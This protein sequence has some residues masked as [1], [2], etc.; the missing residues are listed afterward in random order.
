MF[1]M[2]SY[3]CYD[4]VEGKVACKGKILI[5]N[6]AAESYHPNVFGVALTLAILSGALENGNVPIGASLRMLQI[7][8]KESRGLLIVRNSQPLHLKS[9]NPHIV[10]LGTQKQDKASSPFKSLSLRS[11]VFRFPKY[12]VT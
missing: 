3:V 11:S 5:Q 7:R 6:S 9:I 1:S 8:C 10:L 12:G 2:I 4:L